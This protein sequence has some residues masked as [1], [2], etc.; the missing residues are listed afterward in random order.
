MA[1]GCWRVRGA[2][3]RVAGAADRLRLVLLVIVACGVVQMHVLGHA[4]RDH[5]GDAGAAVPVAH[6]MA[7]AAEPPAADAPA[8]G[9]PGP[10]RSPD[11]LAVCLAILGVVG[12]AVT[13]MILW[14]RWATPSAPA[15]ARL[16]AGGMRRWRGPPLPVPRQARR[17]AALSLLRI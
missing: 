2:V 7:E 1:P 10:E 9:V 11:P 15:A 3:S 13:I 5:A 4:D 8:G 14:I 6:G 16:V 17:L 12:L